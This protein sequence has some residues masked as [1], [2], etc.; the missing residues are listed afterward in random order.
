M[1]A[2]KIHTET[3]KQLG[4]VFF[5]L[6]LCRVGPGNDSTTKKKKNYEGK[7]QKKKFTQEQ[8]NEDATKTVQQKKKIHVFSALLNGID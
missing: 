4:C 3:V 1:L 8:A 6:H 2:K 5:F 7:K